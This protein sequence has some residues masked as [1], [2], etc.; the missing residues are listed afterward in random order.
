MGGHA[1]TLAVSFATDVIST[2]LGVRSRPAS[3]PGLLRSHGL[4]LGG[5]CSLWKHPRYRTLAS[6][7]DGIAAAV[8]RSLACHPEYRSLLDQRKFIQECDFRMLEV[9]DRATHLLRRLGACGV[10]ADGPGPADGRQPTPA[11][12]R[13]V[14]GYKTLY[15][16]DRAGEGRAV[17]SGDTVTVHAK[18][19]VAESGE[20]FWSTRDAGQAPFTYRAGVGGVITGWDQG[21]LGMRLGEVRTLRIPAA[22]GYGA[23]GFP[24]WGIPGGATL[25]FTL[26][27]VS[28][29]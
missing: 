8:G 25:E 24:S 7:L 10:E 11:A 21:C 22:E 28:I 12:F 3:P 2:P 20:K 14:A 13:A 19:V 16:V 17:R 29:V 23:T 18:G 1:G 15:R 6:R 27:C 26:E 9:R 4:L 5:D